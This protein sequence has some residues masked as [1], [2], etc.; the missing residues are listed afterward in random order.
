[1]VIW[2][3]PMAQAAVPQVGVP[4]GV[5]M[6]AKVRLAVSPAGGSKLAEVAP[7]IVVKP[8]MLVPTGEAITPF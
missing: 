6:Q 3:A 5:K 1:M 7:A 4:A 2:R 8:A